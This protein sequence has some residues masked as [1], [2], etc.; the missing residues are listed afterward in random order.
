MNKPVLRTVFRV[1]ELLSWYKHGFLD[2]N[3]RFQRRSVWSPIQ[4]SFLMDTVVCGLPMPIIIMRDE[5]RSLGS[6]E[7]KR[8]VVDGQQRLRTVFAFVDPVALRDYSSSRDDFTV[9]KTHNPGI[10]GRRFGDLL[11]E[12]RQ[13]ILDYEFSVHVLPAGTDD[14]QVVNIF[15]RLNATGVKLNRQELRN[16]EFSG[17]FRMLVDKLSQAHLRHWRDWEILQDQQ[18]ARMLE[19]EL[20]AELVQLMLEGIVGKSQPR[21]TAL[22]RKYEESFK[23]GPLLGRRFDDTM[24]HIEEALEN[25][26]ARTE[27]RRQMWF[28]ALFAVLYDNKFGLPHGQQ[29]GSVSGRHTLPGM[30]TLRRRLSSISQAIAS[31]RIPAPVQKASRGATAHPG[32]RTL[33]VNFLRGRCLG[34]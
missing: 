30:E 12:A 21:L 33:R 7:S 18:I 29:G 16:A 28:H 23:Q 26:I 4:K 32:A 27:F 17:E 24:L 25:R 34:R 5:P 20:T 15:S 19:A 2:L 31:E 9:R 6:L 10:A 3:P 11:P 13:R 14:R 8:E 22:Y 1:S